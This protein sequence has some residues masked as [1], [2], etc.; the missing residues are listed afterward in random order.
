MTKLTGPKAVLDAFQSYES[1]RHRLPQIPRRG[2]GERASG[3]VE[4]AGEFDAFLLDGFGVLNVGNRSIPGAVEAVS[5]L[6]DMGKTVLVL[7]NAAGYPKRLLNE[8]YSDLGFHFS[9]AEAVSSRQVLLS[10]ENGLGESPIGLMADQSF[11]VEELEAF[12]IVFLGDDPVAY[13]AASQFLLLGSGIWTDERQA[14]L[15][16]SVTARPRP[17]LVGNPDLVAPIETGLSRE[18]GLFAHRL[19]DKSGVEPVFYGKPFSNAFEAAL[20]RVPSGITKDRIA[21]VGDTLQTDILGGLAAG[22]RTV[23]VTDYGFFSGSDYD[24]G[25]SLSGIVPDFIIPAP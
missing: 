17:I 4:L 19:A 25:I 7:T 3:L 22:I 20:A 16:A 11:G 15:E 12:D 10:S 8:R 14:I 1:V 6:Q 13:E 2:A 18:P 9:D 23:L 5:A 21:M 24:A